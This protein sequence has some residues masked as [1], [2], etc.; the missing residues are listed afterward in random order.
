M[1]SHNVKLIVS[2][3]VIVTVFLW[4]RYGNF[5]ELIKDYADFFVAISC[6]VIVLVTTLFKFRESRHK[7]VRLILFLLLTSIPILTLFRIQT[8]D[9]PFLIVYCV[10]LAAACIIFR[11]GIKSLLAKY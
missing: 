10:G 2:I 1:L 7:A 6:I 9:L 3:T 8:V 5:K 4:S 11:D